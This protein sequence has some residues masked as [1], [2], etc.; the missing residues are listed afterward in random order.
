M[1]CVLYFPFLILFLVESY[2][3]VSS[4]VKRI[5]HD[6]QVVKQNCTICQV[7]V[8][9]VIFMLYELSE[10]YFV[11]LQSVIVTNKNAF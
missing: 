7:A 1:V 11:P 10:S 9:K 5:C 3:D 6:L 2:G 8:K 4:Q